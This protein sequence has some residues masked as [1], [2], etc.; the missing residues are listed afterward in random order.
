[1]YYLF[2]RIT[3]V[4]E[5]KEYFFETFIIKFKNLILRYRNNCP[6]YVLLRHMH[7]LILPLT[8]IVFF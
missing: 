8:Y 3:H 7:M 2:M 1:M 4:M 6:K 5:S